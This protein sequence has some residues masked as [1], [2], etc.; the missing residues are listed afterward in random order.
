MLRLRSGPHILFVFVVAEVAL[1]GVNLMAFVG[2]GFDVRVTSVDGLNFDVFTDLRL[3]PL[4][5]LGVPLLLW[6]LW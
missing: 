5:L 2:A 3:I 1:P 4:M 6:L